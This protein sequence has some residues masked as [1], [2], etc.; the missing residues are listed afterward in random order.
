MPFD[1]SPLRTAAQIVGGKDTHQ[2]ILTNHLWVDSPTVF[3]KPQAGNRIRPFCT[4]EEYFKDVTESMYQATSEICILGWQVSWDAIVAPGIRLYDVLLKIAKKKTV[5]I[6]VMPWNDAKPLINYDTQ[7]A[8][9]LLSINDHAEVNH[10]VV[11]VVLS[12]TRASKN[13]IYYSHHQKQVIIDRTIA[14]IGGMDLSYGRFDDA[15]YD[16]HANAANRQM[17]NRYNP[18]VEPMQKVKPDVLVDPDKLTGAVDNYAGV[19][20]FVKT[21]RQE[22]L[23]KI[24]KGGWQVPYSASGTAVVLENKFIGYKGFEY[25]ASTPCTLDPATQPR[26]PWQDVHSRIEGPSVSDLLRNFVLRWHASGGSRLQMPA[27]PT[28]YP[29]VGN[30]YI[31]VLRSAP[32][33]LRQEENAKQRPANKKFRAGTENDIQRAMLKLIEKSRRFIYIESQFFVSAFG[34]EGKNETEELSPAAKFISTVSGGDQNADGLMAARADN[35]T[36]L[37]VIERQFNYD[38]VFKP[39]T[40]KVCQALVKRIERAVLDSANPNF[41]VYLTLPV[42]PEGGVMNTASVAIQVYWT[43]QTIHFGTHSLLNG[44]RRAIKARD[45]HDKKDAGFRR[46]ID[47]PANTEYEDVPVEACFKYV[48]LLNLR[49]WA[50]LEGNKGTRYVT[51][52]IYVHTKVMVVDDMYALLGSANIN[53]RSLLGERDSEIAVLVM[54]GDVSR[55]DTCGTG[56]KA[57]VRAYAH[58]LRKKI[59]SKLFGI[60]GNVR[61]ATHLKNAIEQ[62]GIPDSWRSIQKQAEK[63]A[64]A[65]EAAFS[66]IPRSWKKLATGAQVP[67]SI[68]PNWD[69]NKQA[70]GRKDGPLG[71][72]AT[73]LPFMRDFW[74]APMHDKEHVQYLDHLKGFIVALPVYWTKGEMNRF[75]YPTSMVAGHVR[76]KTEKGTVTNTGETVLLAQHDVDA[77]ISAK[78]DV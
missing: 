18:C 12:D 45:L 30:A 29:T 6:Y 75:A 64:Q 5:K 41:H 4:G 71:Y 72:P 57:E 22:E 58:E 3:S 67:A 47:D 48:T 49:N 19:P 38:H 26:M 17:L 40:N 74:A 33:A 73:P 34:K 32:A 23:A 15:R 44:I 65:F 20:G 25:N 66:H 27:P 13:T 43:M 69:S 7:T 16:L 55:A 78:G 35:D 9:V 54:D 59:W 70:P 42:H 8:A 53:D 14:Y 52:Q 60:T 21:S 10:K 36:H 68:V 62:P 28:S 24:A 76:D 50:K 2:S 37:D 61:P 77:A 11:E 39:P 1:P 51:E 31:Q 46:V 63:N 56:S